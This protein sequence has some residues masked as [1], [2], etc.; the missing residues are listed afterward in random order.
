MAYDGKLSSPDVLQPLTKAEGAVE[1][2]RERVGEVLEGL[3]EDEVESM[4]AEFWK[5]LDEMYHQ[6]NLGSFDDLMARISGRGNTDQSEQVVM[7]FL[8]VFIDFVEAKIEQKDFNI[9]LFAKR[10][11]ELLNQ[12]SLAGKIGIVNHFYFLVRASRQ[13]VLRPL[14]TV[15]DYWDRD[16]PW[17]V[18]LGDEQ[19]GPIVHKAESMS[20][21]Q[22]LDLV[23]FCGYLGTLL[24]NDFEYG[25]GHRAEWVKAIL[26]GIKSKQQNAFLSYSI[27]GALKKIDDKLAHERINAGIDDVEDDNFAQVAKDLGITVEK[28]LEWFNAHASQI[29]EWEGLFTDR[30]MYRFSQLSEADQAAYLKIKEEGDEREIREKSLGYGRFFE[31]FS[32]VDQIR[33]DL[34]SRRINNTPEFPENYDKIP[35]QLFPVSSDYIGVFDASS[36]LQ[37]IA[38]AKM[39]DLPTPPATT[40][41][42]FKRLARVTSELSFNPFQNV[43][44][45]DI[46]LLLQQLHRPRMREMVERELGLALD[47]MPLATQFQLL[48]FMAEESESTFARLRAV[49][50][51]EEGARQHFLTAFLACAQDRT[52]GKVILEL[53]KEPASH[54]LF[55]AYAKIAETAESTA[56]TLYAQYHEAQPDALLST[57][58]LFRALMSRANGLMGAYYYTQT[59]KRDTSSIIR[60]LENETA[61]VAAAA[62]FFNSITD[63]LAQSQPVDL[64]HYADQ[65]QWILSA[66]NET[67]ARSNILQ[68]LQGKGLLL[69]VPE[70]FWRV[71]RSTEEYNARFGFDV[72]AFLEHF[73]DPHR[74]QVILEFGPGNG[75]FR[76]QRSGVSSNYLDFALSDRLYYPINTLIQ[77]LIDFDVLEIPLHENQKTILADFL[78]KIL[79]IKPGQ[80]SES[81]FEYDQDVLRRIQEDPSTIIQ[82]LKSKAH[83]LRATQAV[84]AGGNVVGQSV[85]YENK[86][87]RPSDE[88]FSRACDLISNQPE[89]YFKT[90]DNVY[91]L[92]PA[93]PPGTIISDFNGI[94]KLSD[95][96]LDVA[97]GVRSTVYKQGEDYIKFMTDMSNKVANDGFYIDDNVRE[98]FGSNYRL[99]ELREIQ[100]RTNYPLHL[101]LGPGMKNEDFNEGQPVPL[102]VVMS[103]SQDK[104]SY[105]RSHLQEGYELVVLDGVL[106]RADYLNSLANGRT[107]QSLVA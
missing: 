89:K 33:S 26:Q 79:V 84:P 63:L 71:D 67:G 51:G 101:I 87:H 107:A 65:Q 6:G 5:W 29:E 18:A 81:S 98:N 83:L 2:R 39:V 68:L 53:A 36:T 64:R 9:D 52:Y 72:K 99:R 70:I 16:N 41:L 57:S 34:L 91:D 86:I 45:Q 35:A 32:K 43:S 3:T 55:K 77:R 15:D 90:S 97:V 24:A 50:P 10:F 96:Q 44:A 37:Y 22:L 93:Y 28:Y 92:M 104:L 27:D 94:E 42:D 12:E 88:A 106:R 59:K 76:E 56:Q 48:Q 85:T 75:T 105:V 58:D 31:A 38:P 102:A 61:H 60:T 54:N 23:N 82:L 1:G 19:I 103:R 11:S 73:S 13:M 74:K 49:L 80:A 21:G 4:K 40:T 46:P 17:L 7:L 8:E 69:P 25:G 30:E 62:T 66:L 95:G 78:Y 20:P 14:L 100:Q 47:E